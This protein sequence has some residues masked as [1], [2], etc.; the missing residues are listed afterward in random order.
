MFGLLSFPDSPTE[1]D[2]VIDTLSDP[3]TRSQFIRD[4]HF[5]NFVRSGMALDNFSTL[6]LHILEYLGHFL[7]LSKERGQ[8]NSDASQRGRRI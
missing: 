4:N 1:N 8:K 2:D 6:Y 3:P 5:R 7:F